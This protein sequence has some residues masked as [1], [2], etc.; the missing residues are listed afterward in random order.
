M[1]TDCELVLAILSDGAWHNAEELHDRVCWRY[2]ARLFNLRERGVVMEKRT[3]EFNGLDEWRL[4]ALP[5]APLTFG[6]QRTTT[7]KHLPFAHPPGV[8]FDDRGQGR[9][10]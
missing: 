1:A 8:T 6:R 4:V 9:M 5:L 2:G 10:L 7:V 3:S